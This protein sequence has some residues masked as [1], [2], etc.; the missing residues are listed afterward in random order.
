M[1]VSLQ[2]QVEHNTLQMCLF[3]L[4]NYLVQ[5]EHSISVVK[6]TDNILVGAALLERKRMIEHSYFYKNEINGHLMIGNE[7]INV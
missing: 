6:I 2:S 3:F 4:D 5:L 7:S 1:C